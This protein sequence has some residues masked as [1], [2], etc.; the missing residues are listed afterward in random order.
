MGEPVPT[1][2]G[3]VLQ[4]FE[5]L[6]PDDS[7]ARSVQ[8]TGSRLTSS[9][10]AAKDF[11]NAVDLASSE[12]PEF[13]VAGG[14]LVMLFG[15]NAKSFNIPTLLD[16]ILEHPKLE[17]FEWQNLVRGFDRTGLI[18]GKD[19]FLTLYDALLGISHRTQG[20]FDVQ[21]LWGGRWLNRE[22]QLSFL[23]AFASCSSEELDISQIPNL[24]RA[25]D[26]KTFEDAPE[27]IREAGAQALRHPLSTLDA[28]SAIFD[29]V[30]RSVDTWQT[31]EGQIVYK[32][33]VQPQLAVFIASA[34]ACPKPWTND[35]E[36][37]LLKMFLPFFLKHYDSHKIVLYTMWFQDKH[38]LSEKLLSLHMQDPTCL[39][40]IFEHAQEF[41]WLE[42]L[43]EFTSAFG[44]DLASLAHR[45][46]VLDLE[47]WMGRMR[48]RTTA[49]IAFSLSRFLRIKADDEIRTQRNEQPGPKTVS[50]AVKTV[51]MLL[52]TLEQYVM[53]R[54]NITNVQ[55]MCIQAYPRLIN[56]NEGFDDIIDENGENS[57]AIP[58]ATDKQMQDLFGKMYHGDLKINQILEHMR[59]YKNSK[60]PGEQDLFA[61]MVHGL[62]DEYHCYHEYPI[63]ALTKTAVM[64]GG[65]INFNL[66][67]G[68]PLKVALGMILDAVR[69]HPPDASMFKFGH[70]ALE[71][72]ID[73]LHEWAGFCSLLVE[74]DKLK[75]TAVY[76][77][78][79]EVLQQ[80][81][82]HT[83]GDLE[84][85]GVNGGADGFHLS[86]GI[87]DQP[88][89]PDSTVQ[90]FRCLHVDEP[91]P[92][93]AYEDPNEDVQD[94]TLFVLNNVTD[95]NLE[96]KLE[97][98]R[99]VLTEQHRPWFANYLVEERAK[100]QPNFQRLYL[101][102][103]DG[104]NDKALWSEV[105][106]ETFIS[107]FRM[108]NAESTL[109]S[110]TERA[111]LK[112]LGEWLGSLTLARDKPIKHKNIYFR[113][114]L[115]EGY[116]THRLVVV[117]PF[118]CKV[119][120]QGRKSTIFKPPNPW[121]MDIIRLLI[122]LYHHAE[123]KL[124]LKF[125]IE[126]L[127]KDFELDHKT[128]IPAT[129]I[130]DRPL[131]E[132]DINGPTIPDGLEGF[133]D[134]SLSVMNRTVRNERF[135]P[136]EILANLPDIGP[137]LNYPPPTNSMINP[138]RLKHVVQTAIQRAI[139]EIISPVVER[140]VTIAAIA[141]AQL[142]I[143]DF[144]ME[145]DENKVRDAA[146]TMVKALAGSLALVTCKEP[147][148][149]SMNNY[150]RI[151]HQNE[152]DG[153]T[154][155][156]GIVLM[157]V[158][159][160]LDTACD[161]VEKAA[162]QRAIPEIHA[163]IEEQLTARRRH[164]TA[165]PNDHFVDPIVNRWSFYVPE[166]Y[167]QN[168]GGLNQ[169]QLSIYEDFA[170]QT[171]LPSATHAQS[172]SMDSVRQLPDVLQESFP[173]VPNLPTPAEPPAI[174]H[175]TPHQLQ[176]RHVQPPPMPT[177]S[178]QP[179]INGFLDGV[180][181]RDKLMSLLSE[182]QQSARS[183][184]ENESIDTKPDNNI[185]AK[186][187]QFDRLIDIVQNIDEVAITIAQHIFQVFYGFTENT[188]E[189][190][191]L[192][193]LLDRICVASPATRKEVYLYLARL[194]DEQS[195]NVPTTIQLIQHGLID[196][197]NLDTNLAKSIAKKKFSALEL[198]AK[199]ID[200]MLFREQPIG[201]RADFASCL[202]AM[203][204]WLAEQPSLVP[205]REIL[206][207][208]RASGVPEVPVQDLDDQSRFKHDQMAYVF[209]EWVS[210]Y[211][212]P[213]TN[214]K[215]YAAFIQDMHKRQIMNNQED[216]ILFFRICLEE[217]VDVFEREEFSPVQSLSSAFGHT[218]ALAKLIVLLVKYQGEAN[219][220]VKASKAAYLHSILSLVVLVLNHHQVMRGER[221]C[222]RVFFRL[223]SSILCEYNSSSTHGLAQE[224]EVLLVFADIF[225]ILQPLH[226]P[227]FTY[228][229][230]ALISHRVFMPALLSLPDQA[231][232][233]IYSQIVQVMLAYISELLKPVDITAVTK[234][235]YKSVLR[236]LLVLH[237]D[238]PEFVAENHFKLC[239]VIPAY[240]TQLR[241]LIL[242]A[243]PSV[244][245]ELPD[246]FT[247][248]L[249]VD[250]LEEIRKSPSIA[251]DIVGPL[252]K[253]DILEVVEEAVRND[254]AVDAAAQK[255]SKAIAESASRGPEEPLSASP[256]V[257]LTNALVLHI[258]QSAIASSQ[259]RG[260]GHNF[261]AT[262][263]QALLL[264]KL[265]QELQPE[266]RYHF[267]S[268]IA[269]QLRYPN[270]H[271]YYFSYAMLHLFGTDHNDQLD[272]DIS[273]Q[274]ARV[275]LERLV[276]HRPHPWGLIITLLELLKNPSYMFWD[277]SF[278]K[279]A[280]E[281]SFSTLKD[282]YR[283]LL[284]QT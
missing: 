171:N 11:I 30:F 64:F 113:D 199:L 156:E 94:K 27:S 205:A 18:I 225:L 23:V 250:R 193:I 35:Q 49:D 257:V 67:S 207:R 106:R 55:R 252:R 59:T 71:Q 276:V 172:G 74:M 29:L 60:D 208:L 40:I 277:L 234:E 32:D 43:L 99:G 34:A 112:N 245:Q 33:V 92:S 121:L 170:R 151:M 210:L 1:M 137:L 89:S 80:A 180:S 229:W 116:D 107:S 42:E 161:M 135:S 263:P 267:L 101:D 114:L 240:C 183:I 9:T 52:E 136:S 196:M 242:S 224:K 220:A 268:A 269:N 258:G 73:R 266:A 77:R 154:M 265:A 104:L 102:L 173:P 253:A 195:F 282:K 232:W 150:I 115:V 243:F 20:L 184:P 8:A 122:E 228:G 12:A 217:S 209:Q 53:D 56:Y 78:A 186:L 188:L 197:G 68:V 249:K 36:S 82:S 175:Q 149:M 246:P 91:Y 167:R 69:D 264:R 21:S 44:L 201:L 140:S 128:I 214:E 181:A 108:L 237:H 61:C 66:I 177:P 203:G 254:V 178:A 275:I 283:R 139:M 157:C 213:A 191:L 164:R 93:G 166:P 3:S 143:K 14:L 119:L 182:M 5:I 125:E 4:L 105:I 187:A 131:Q 160:N 273:Q 278:I 75:G 231:G 153:E 124:N 179:Q 152:M 141:T 284:H 133:E 96:A 37:F 90:R 272:A 169:E 236:I 81:D 262:S 48:Q 279:S 111:H 204:R 13:Q 256:E 239:N 255:I 223:F 148:R 235:L 16:A 260:A 45:R 216:S 95:Q 123:L 244:F 165:R 274:I 120:L 130:R 39:P 185:H 31:P 57:N 158:N 281:V 87:L 26:P 100:L 159:D 24:R 51:H 25:I 145:G 22:T 58:E 7:F 230:L 247:A 215:S 41:G 174:T 280:P 109:N 6:R 134:L 63:E 168:L 97:E 72:L 219:G 117:I 189:I 147:L 212:H 65:I 138:N 127:C 226:A 28:A 251:G 198:F 88:L 259:Q 84:A 206:D 202:E 38:W 129:T 221:F 10:T 103:L 70:E 194:D 227:A 50:L 46:G 190:E 54:E 15:T 47:R 118:T 86:N 17:G 200:E 142:I 76:A 222:Q 98:L 79:S 144:A 211:T 271:T 248:G 270:S 126:V 192:V 62:L 146:Q 155:P 261:V 2:L 241:N 163:N 83:G 110:S 19:H 85:N 162:A 176:D 218:D 233:E 132:E 238:F